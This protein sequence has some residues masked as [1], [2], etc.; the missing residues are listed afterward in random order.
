MSMDR[1]ATRRQVEYIKG[2]KAEMG[3]DT[4]IYCYTARSEVLE[5]K[6]AGKQKL[7]VGKASIFSNVTWEQGKLCFAF[8]HLD[9]SHRKYY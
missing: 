5:K 7:V 2:L 8:I 1:P 6:E 9:R 3:E 4:P